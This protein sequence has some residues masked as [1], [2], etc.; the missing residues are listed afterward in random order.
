[1]SADAARPGQAA[2]ARQL[3]LFDALPSPPASPHSSPQVPPRAAPPQPS[4]TPDARPGAAPPSP[5]TPLVTPL[6]TPAPSGAGSIRAIRLGEH[7]VAY[8]LRRARR[9]TIGFV[10]G[11]DGL[12]VSAPRWVS[13]ADIEAALLEKSRW[14]CARLVESRERARRLEAARIDWRD[15]AR[16]PF[17]G[18]PL[19]VVLDPR[20]PGVVLDAAEPA[21]GPGAEAASVAGDAAAAGRTTARVGERRLRVGLP[22]P[23]APEQIRDA[24]Q[25]WLQRQARRVFEERCSHFAE[26]LG[27]RVGRLALSSAATR[28]GSA[29]ADGSIRLNWR[30]VHFTLPVIDYVVAHELA[31]L[32]EMNHG[33]RFWDVV[34]SVLPGFEHARDA[35]R[36]PDLPLL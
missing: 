15:G 7:V 17:L 9:R 33:P 23:A 3:L 30:L 18:A 2:A 14:I 5:S 6:V 28:W 8:R 1:M 21:P 16:V 35:L 34:R 26:R 4:A 27:V 31:H 29:S 11:A 32:R 22:A 19:V 12:T 36:D 20:T 24:V 13:L 10:V 25:G